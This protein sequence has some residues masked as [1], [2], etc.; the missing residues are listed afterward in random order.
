MRVVVLVPFNADGSGK[1]RLSPVLTPDE[2]WRLCLSM[3]A[4]TLS[5][6]RRAVLQGHASETLVVYRPQE[7]GLAPPDFAETCRRCEAI[8]LEDGRKGLDDGI[9]KATAY[10][11][12]ELGAQATVVV[13]PDLV[14]FDSSVLRRVKRILVRIDGGVVLCPATGGGLS[15][16]ARKPADAIQS[17]HDADGPPSF[18]RHLEAARKANVEVHLLDSLRGHVDLDVPEDLFLLLNYMS[19]FKPRCPTTLLLRDLVKN[20]S[21]EPFRAASRDVQLRLQTI[22]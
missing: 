16:W 2:R 9:S 7:P 19:T 18:V 22:K 3:L 8:A 14:L 17:L 4:D 13:H 15:L 21:V 6:C 20:L 5:E 10:A 11:V 1:S 12:E